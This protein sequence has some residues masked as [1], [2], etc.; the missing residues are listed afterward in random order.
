MTTTTERITVQEFLEA[1]SADRGPFGNLGGLSVAMC[2]AGLDLWDETVEAIPQI[3]GS[4]QL[5]IA[6]RGYCDDLDL[7]QG[8]T[9]SECL[10]AALDVHPQFNGNNRLEMLQA[11]LKDYGL[12]EG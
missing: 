7:P 8:S 2:E 11:M 3:A 6:N 12:I 1:V 10:A 4:N 9:F 5:C